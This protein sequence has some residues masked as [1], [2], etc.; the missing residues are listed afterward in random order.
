MQ[1]I[2][3]KA[4]NATQTVNQVQV[5]TRSGQPAVIK[6]NGNMHYEFVK[7]ATGR[8]PDHIITKRAGKDLHVSFEEL[9]Q[10]TDLRIEDF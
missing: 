10:S 6:A 3:V 9:G 1:N 8:A 5:V 2:T 4:N 7:D